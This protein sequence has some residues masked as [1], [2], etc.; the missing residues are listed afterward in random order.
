[1]GSAITEFVHAALGRGI[2]R[3]DIVRALQ[4]GGW[5]AREIERA[6]D[7]FVESDLPLPVPRPSGFPGPPGRPFFF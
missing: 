4:Q 1:M 5:S 3:A 6:L 7:C 2:A